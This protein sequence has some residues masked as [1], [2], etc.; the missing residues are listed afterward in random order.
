[1]TQDN[2]ERTVR[3]LCAFLNWGYI[4]PVCACNWKENSCAHGSM[5]IKN[6]GPIELDIVIQKIKYK[7]NIT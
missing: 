3:E 4:C 5:Y 7:M 6:L 2:N 1:M